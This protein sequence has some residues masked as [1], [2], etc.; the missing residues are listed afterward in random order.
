LTAVWLVERFVFG[1]DVDV[2]FLPYQHDWSRGPRVDCVVDMA[3]LH[4]PGLLLFDHKPP[5]RDNRNESC[6]TELVW[7]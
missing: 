5:S 7:E 3:G 4:D 1:C 2:V 6:V